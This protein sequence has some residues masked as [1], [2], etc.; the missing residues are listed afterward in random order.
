MSPNFNLTNQ[1]SFAIAAI[2]LSSFVA[3]AALADQN[4][5]I[6]SNTYPSGASVNTYPSYPSGTVFVQPTY[7]ARTVIVNPTHYHR[8]NFG[9]YPRHPQTVIVAP[10]TRTVIINNS[11]PKA[12]QQQCGTSVIGSPIPRPGPVDFYTGKICW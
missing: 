3:P 8:S 5:I 6:Y 7:P 10:R 4:A 1:L 12:Q 2:V 9:V 11:A